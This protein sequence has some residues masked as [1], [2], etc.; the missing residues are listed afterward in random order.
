[1]WYARKTN[2][3][4]PP[5]GGY[6]SDDDCDDVDVATCPLDTGEVDHD[7]QG[8]DDRHATG[9][10]A[11]PEGEGM[12]LSYGLDSFYLGPANFK[13]IKFINLTIFS[14]IGNIQANM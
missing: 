12:S 9:G 14:R 2:R 5:D 7:G 6:D 3:K 11:E 8:E 4:Y 10:T 13:I 1:M